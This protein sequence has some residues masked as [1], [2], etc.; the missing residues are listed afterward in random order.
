MSRTLQA[1]AKVARIQFA[2]ANGK[3]GAF[4][5]SDAE[6]YQHAQN[7]YYSKTSEELVA[8]IMMAFM[9]DQGLYVTGFVAVQESYNQTHEQREKNSRD[10]FHAALIKQ[11]HGLLGVKPRIQAQD[12]G[13]VAIHY[14]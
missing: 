8:T 1:D 9:R 10:A 12:D 7:H 6:S 11:V 5:Y 14:E 3:G 2:M 4:K 13:C